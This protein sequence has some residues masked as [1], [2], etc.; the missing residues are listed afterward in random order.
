MPSRAAPPAYNT[1]I[2]RQARS[3]RRDGCCGHTACD[4][5]RDRS[6]ALWVH[7]ASCL[8]C[9]V[10]AG[11]A[12]VRAVPCVGCVLW[13]WSSWSSCMR[14]HGHPSSC[15]RRVPVMSFCACAV[16]LPVPLCGLLYMHV[17]RGAYLCAVSVRCCCGMIC[18]LAS[19]FTRESVVQS[20]RASS[21]GL[22]RAHEVLISYSCCQCSQMAACSARARACRRR[23]VTPCGNCANGGEPPLTLYV[24]VSRGFY[25][26]VVV[27]TGRIGVHRLSASGGSYDGTDARICDCVGFNTA[28]HS[29]LKF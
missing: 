6:H 2:S 26:V 16:V 10:F 1:N 4:T 11:C 19:R 25:V 9:W 12:V 17:P 15:A 5:W 18:G 7:C 3:A 27:S 29:E 23:P 24:D 8:F 13:V 22:R 14:G 21:L 20:R 28:L